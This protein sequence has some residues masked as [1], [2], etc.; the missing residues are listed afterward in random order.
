MPVDFKTATGDTGATGTDASAKASI[1][2]ATNGEP[3]NETTLQRPTEHLRVRTDELKRS[4]IETELQ[5]RFEQGAYLTTNGDDAV[6]TY[7]PSVSAAN[8]DE[9]PDAPGYRFSMGDSANDRISIVSPVEGH[10]SITLKP[11]HLDSFFTTAD[12]HPSNPFSSRYLYDRGDTLSLVFPLSGATARENWT[13]GDASLT[14]PVSYNESSLSAPDLGESYYAILPSKVWLH[15]DNVTSL[16]TSYGSAAGTAY[17]AAESADGWCYP[18]NAYRV[19]GIASGASLIFLTID[20]YA[21]GG[22]IAGNAYKWRDTGGR[23]GWYTTDNTNNPPANTISKDYLRV[24]RIKANVVEVEDT[25]SF[26]RILSKAQATITNGFLGWSLHDYGVTAANTYTQIGGA[27]AGSHGYTGARD[28]SDSHVV[29]LVTFTGNGFM[30]SPNG[31]FLKASGASDDLNSFQIPVGMSIDL[32]DAVGADQGAKL[33]GAEAQTY[34]SLSV[35]S[36]TQTVYAGLTDL[37][38]HAAESVRTRV[39]E[40]DWATIKAVHSGASNAGYVVATSLL[41]DCW[42]DPNSVNTA[43]LSATVHLV[44][45]FATA[46]GNTIVLD[47]GTDNTGADNQNLFADLIVSD[48]DLLGEY[49]SNLSGTANG[50]SLVSDT[51]IPATD[52]LMVKITMLGPDGSNNLGTLTAGRVRLVVTYTARSSGF[53]SAVDTVAGA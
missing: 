39:I 14:A 34:G 4:V 42:I 17:F 37:L 10:T 24:R 30:M 51:A 9:V 2:P 31:G 20:S 33:I 12:A 29:P 46:G 18:A 8:R 25:Y 1:Q 49:R 26:R 41:E 40:V 35:N 52:D 28:Y 6:I 15:D 47:S 16:V 45:A 27:V 19:G 44:E 7:T 22:H 3:L 50:V 43:V 5:H 13:G 38:H 11:T 36:S 23:G 32:D 21:V 53:T 48:S